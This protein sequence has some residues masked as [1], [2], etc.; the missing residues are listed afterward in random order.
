[1]SSVDDYDSDSSKEDPSFRA[2]TPHSNARY[3]GSH[4]TGWAH[5]S[6]RRVSRAESV[7]RA[8][9]RTVIAGQAS[10]S[11]AQGSSLLQGQDSQARLPQIGEGVGPRVTSVS[12][13]HGPRAAVLIPSAPG[14]Q[15][16]AAGPLPAGTSSQQQM[17]AD[18]SPAHQ[19]KPEVTITDVDMSAPGMKPTQA[20][21]LDVDSFYFLIG[22]TGWKQLDEVPGLQGNYEILRHHVTNR[23][24]SP[25][26][27]YITVAKGVGGVVRFAFA[28]DITLLDPDCRCYKKVITEEIRSPGLRENSFTS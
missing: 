18:V 25:D 12:A 10:S 5:L 3:S 13:V 27:E 16:S 6:S 9:G 11:A 21:D 8:R 23:A 14:G 17:A 20:A 7:A 15:H 24:D 2:A 1:M 19:H 28:K 26:L 22:P 4:R